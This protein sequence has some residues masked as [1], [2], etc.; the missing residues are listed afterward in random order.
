M[1]GQLLYPNLFNKLFRVV[2][3][4]IAGYYDGLDDVED[5]YD[6]INYIWMV[7]GGDPLA[8]LDL[9]TFDF[10]EHEMYY[11]SRLLLCQ[12]A[13]VNLPFY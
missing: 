10:G 8:S 11:C 12:S 4:Q 2:S 9:L 3:L 6:W 13:T 5:L 1:D 7:D